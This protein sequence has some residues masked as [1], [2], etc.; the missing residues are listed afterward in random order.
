LPTLSFLVIV[1][2]LSALLVAMLRRIAERRQVLDH[3]NE[4]S[5]HSRPTPRL[6]GLAIVLLVGVASLSAWPGV[7]LDRPWDVWWL[8][9]LAVAAVSLYDDLYGLS[10]GARLTAHVMAAAAVALVS[11]LSSVAVPLLGTVELG[12]LA[13]PLT[14]IWLVGLTNAYNFMDGIDGI[15]GGQGLVAGMCLAVAGS[16][17]GAAPVATTGAVIAAACLGFLVH[18]WY[19][20]RIFMGDVGSAYLGFSIGSLTCLAGSHHHAFPVVVIWALWPFLYD[21]V[22]TFLRRARRRENLFMAHRSHLYQRLVTSGLRHDV[23]AGLYIV[24]ATVGAALG[25]AFLTGAQAAGMAGAV[26]IPAMALALWVA[27]V[28]REQRV[29]GSHA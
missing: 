7:M 15:A 8:S 1:A 22:F 23:V 9:G 24:L 13:V 3:P 12:A 18:N 16:A 17:T 25:L 6:G 14:I 27:V 11:P 19:P 2:A 21:T 29:S 10:S 26:V 20:A 4:R 5:S 28:L